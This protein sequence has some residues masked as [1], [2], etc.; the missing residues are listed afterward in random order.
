[1]EL[2][3]QRKVLLAVL[4]LGGAAL[5]LDYF[6]LRGSPAASEGSP[7]PASG[8]TVPVASKKKPDAPADGAPARQSVAD[9]LAQLP[10]VGGEVS[11]AFS[12]TPEWLEGK[13]AQSPGLVTTPSAPPTP[14]QD[15]KLAS[16]ATM[17][18]PEGTTVETAVVLTPEGG[19]AKR[20]VLKVGDAIGAMTLASIDTKAGT[21]TF[22]DG[23]RQWTIRSTQPQLKDTSR[24]KASGNTRA[25]AP[26][27]GE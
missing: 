7:A 2:T 26:K 18:S 21:A 6:V 20:R 16:V 23:Q 11:D 3:R 17:K 15:F 19:K 22:W 27:A 10:A 8:S 13:A 9:R 14:T 12:G 1:M 24:V 4:A 25:A 5:G